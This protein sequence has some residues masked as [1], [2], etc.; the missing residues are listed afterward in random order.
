MENKQ[1]HHTEHHHHHHHHHHSNGMA[2]EKVTWKDLFARP[3]YSDE[4]SKLRFYME[5]ERKLKGFK[6]RIILSLV[7]SIAVVVVACVFFA[8]FIDR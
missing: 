5:K 6:Q 7:L 1:Q 8:Y 2:E 3:K 4:T